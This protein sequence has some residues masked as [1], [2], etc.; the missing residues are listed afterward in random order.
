MA[1]YTAFF[2]VGNWV[3][4]GFDWTRTNGRGFFD[5]L[6]DQF[7][8]SCSQCPVMIGYNVQSVVDTENHLIIA[9]EVTNVGNRVSL[10]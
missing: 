8:I 2:A 7:W 10:I 1:R 9:H 5:R 6:C 3:Q 4:A